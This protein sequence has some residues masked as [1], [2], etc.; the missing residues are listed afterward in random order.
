M[1]AESTED[2]TG[3]G[4][5]PTSEPGAAPDQIGQ[6]RTGS[7]QI[8]QNQT[9][10]DQIG[11]DQIGQ[12]QT[13]QDQTGLPAVPDAPGPLSQ[14]GPAALPVP[15]DVLARTRLAVAWPPMTYWVRAT[16]VVVAT[17]A[18]VF[19]ARQVTHV[20][21]LVVIA[22]VLAVGMDPAVRW[23]GQ[24]RVRRG[25][26]V[27]LIF[28]GLVLFLGLFLV[29]LIPAMVRQIQQFAG[30]LPDYL[31]DLQARED[32]VGN[33]ARRADI[34]DRVQAFIADI[35]SRVGQS[36]NT[37]I[38]FAGTIFGR[39][40]DLFTVG[41]LSI[42][43]MLSL[44]SLGRLVASLTAPAHRAQVGTVLERSLEK[45]GGYVIGN[46]ITSAVCGVLAVIALLAIRVPYAVPL[47]LWAGVADLIPMVGSYLGAI[48]AVLVALTKG[49]V[50]GLVTVA[51][52]IA[53][54][55][56][57]NYVL[58]PRVY[59]NAIDLSPAAVVVST[60]IGGSLAGFAGALLAL[61]VAATIKV[62]IFDVWLGGRFA[63]Q[64]AQR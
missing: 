50:Y 11:Q 22:F 59:K 37:I 63:E 64:S 60:L 18:V 54:Q 39:V 14:A 30:A 3:R 20:L 21:L 36:F 47:G 2:G 1:S 26:A 4:P 17:L 55:Q 41:I 42:Y 28:S 23:L 51:Y 34:S 8:G 16:L 48:P 61:P 32:W 56:F 15:S 13:G 7:N 62:V 45:I 38:G 10:S 24:F 27:T 44:P 53:Y 35:P 52:F 9:G 25:W 31:R 57:E 33:L 40:F 46:L 12:D 58:A 29:L 5:G 6:D 49:P 19:A 43:F